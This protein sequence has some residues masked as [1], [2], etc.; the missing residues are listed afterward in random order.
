MKILLSG[1]GLALADICPPSAVLPRVDFKGA[2]AERG[3]AFHDFLYNVNKKGLG[4]ALE[5]ASP[6]YR[7]NLAALDFDR[8]PLDPALYAAEVAFAYDVETGVARELGRG[9]GREA[10]N[11]ACG[12]NEMMGTAD[13]VSLSDGG[14]LVL[15][16]KTGWTDYGPL[17]NNWQ[18]AFYAL[19]AARAYGVDKARVGIVRIRDDGSH[20][21][22]MEDLDFFDLEDVAFRLSALV[23]RVRAAKE[24]HRAGGSLR[25]REGE[26]CARC[27]AMAQCPA[28]VTLVRELAATPPEAGAPALT[29]ETAAGIYQRARA[30]RAALKRIETALEAWAAEHPIAASAGKVYGRTKLPRDVFVPD[31]AVPVLREAFGDE[32]V[33]RAIDFTPRITKEGVKRALMVLSQTQRDMKVSLAFRDLEKRLLQSGGLVTKFTYPVMVHKPKSAEESSDA[34]QSPEASS[35]DA[36]PE[37]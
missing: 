26:H 8:L 11:R 16:Y 6:E 31:I 19:C 2:P 15:D 32:F 14:V 37:A 36:Q 30:M 22:D 34:A 29:E 20:Y 33:E 4:D 13:V 9:I 23:A 25:M 21:M 24:T 7:E 1:S 27:P 10:A 17:K 35:Q 18:L 12:P 3:T 5:L 28:M